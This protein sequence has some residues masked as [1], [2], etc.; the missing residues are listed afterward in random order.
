MPPRSGL[1]TVSGHPDHQPP[2]Q[3]GTQVDRRHSQQ[4]NTD[5][6]RVPAVASL[7]DYDADHAK[8]YPPCRNHPVWEVVAGIVVKHLR[9]VQDDKAETQPEI[10][11]PEPAAAWRGADF[12]AGFSGDGGLGHSRCDAVVL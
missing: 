3:F 11:Y 8:N 6:E 4:G 7:T 9:D 2:D 5:P 10:F 12:K 1:G